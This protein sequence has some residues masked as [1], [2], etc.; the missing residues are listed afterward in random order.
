[1]VRAKLKSLL[2]NQQKI[3]AIKAHINPLNKATINS[4]KSFLKIDS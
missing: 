1:M 3:N 4:L 2:V